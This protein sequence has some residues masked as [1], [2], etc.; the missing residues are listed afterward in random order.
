MVE[1]RRTREPLKRNEVKPKPK[2]DAIVLTYSTKENWDQ[3]D[4]F[5]QIVLIQDFN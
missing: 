1:N 4:V 5:H 2:G 3:C